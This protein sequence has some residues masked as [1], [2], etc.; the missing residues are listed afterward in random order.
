MILIQLNNYKCLNTF[1]VTVHASITNRQLSMVLKPQPH[2]LT[3]VLVPKYY[4]NLKKYI[5]HRI[6]IYT[7]FKNI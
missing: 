7:I 4:T 2:S 6:F 1:G 5:L 3:A